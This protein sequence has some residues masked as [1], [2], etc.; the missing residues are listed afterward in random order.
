MERLFTK[1]SKRSYFKR[2]LDWT[3][4]AGLL[5]GLHLA[6]DRDENLARIL[7]FKLVVNSAIALVINELNTETYTN[8]TA[9]NS[10]SLF[11]SQPTGST[12]NRESNFQ[13]PEVYSKVLIKLV[14]KYINSQKDQANLEQFYCSIIGTNQINAPLSMPSGKS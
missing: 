1:I 13:V 12:A 4:V 5:S 8:P 6:L 7:Y 2:Q 11:V 9:L 14:G 10:S 3:A